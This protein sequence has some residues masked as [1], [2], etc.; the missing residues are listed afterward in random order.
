MRPVLQTACFTLSLRP[1]IRPCRRSVLPGLRMFS[2]K[3]TTVAS[4]PCTSKPQ[5]GIRIN[6]I[7]FAASRVRLEGGPQTLT[8][9]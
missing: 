4:H 7:A 9:D 2:A 1:E 8:L 3:A 5:P 6:V